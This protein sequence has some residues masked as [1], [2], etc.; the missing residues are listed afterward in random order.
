MKCIWNY[1]IK[2]I[3]YNNSNLLT[4]VASSDGFLHFRDDVSSPGIP[5]ETEDY[6][7]LICIAQT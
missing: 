4:I 6:S 2:I 7:S 1:L 3:S 5:C